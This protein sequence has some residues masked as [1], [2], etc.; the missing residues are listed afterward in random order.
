MGWMN[1]NMD[2]VHELGSLV[3]NL[4]IFNVA[5]T[6]AKQVAHQVSCTVHLGRKGHVY[7][8]T[9]AC[10]M[11]ASR[12]ISNPLRG[13]VVVANQIINVLSTYR[14]VL[15]HLSNFITHCNN[16]EFN[17][18]D[19]FGMDAAMLNSTVLHTRPDTNIDLSKGHTVTTVFPVVELSCDLFSQCPVID[20]LICAV[21]DGDATMWKKFQL[22][23]PPGT[24]DPHHQYCDWHKGQN[25]KKEGE[26]L[27]SLAQNDR[28]RRGQVEYDDMH[29]LGS[30]FGNESGSYRKFNTLFGPLLH[31]VRRHESERVV[32]LFWNLFTEKAS[33]CGMFVFPNS[34]EKLH[35]YKTGT[36]GRY[37]MCTFVSEITGRVKYGCGVTANSIEAR[38]NKNIKS[39]L[40]T[41]LG[42]VVMHAIVKKSCSSQCRQTCHL[43]YSLR[44]A[45][46]GD[47]RKIYD[48][49]EYTQYGE[50]P[51]GA[52]WR[53]QWSLG[54]NRALDDAYWNTYCWQHGPSWP[55]LE[56]TIATNAAVDMCRKM[57]LYYDDA[58]KTLR[59]YCTT[60]KRDWQSF[61]KDPLKYR[62][63]L[64]AA[65]QSFT[66][67]RARDHVV[68]AAA[69][70]NVPRN[71]RPSEA[72]VFAI[73]EKDLLFQQKVRRVV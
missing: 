22:H 27:L 58:S 67:T 29:K 12:Y 3:H 23:L 11:A 72:E 44:Q 55:D 47:C 57:E 34:Y 62:T 71:W 8:G 10:I 60:L 56:F 49:R 59:D 1:Y 40:G 31:V 73:V 48:R 4:N 30:I 33:G 21:T 7:E 51:F 24:Y 37:G 64:V 70:L 13:I 53:Q 43:R 18:Q 50:N 42:F 41:K 68:D 9:S 61:K 16:L 26:G 2:V 14:F 65:V 52:N 35:H 63:A 20:P 5:V 6:D 66:S 38:A 36:S 17:I 25:L 32:E 28:I 19:F 54:V 45:C 46:H 39:A 69:Y 15:G